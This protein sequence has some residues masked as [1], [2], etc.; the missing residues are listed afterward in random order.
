MQVEAIV[1]GTDSTKQHVVVLFGSAA[2]TFTPVFV[3]IC[4]ASRGWRTSHSLFACGA[5]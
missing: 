3:A 5:Q 4:A 2:S 1:G